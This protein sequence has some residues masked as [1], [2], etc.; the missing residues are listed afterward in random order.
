MP[1]I[2]IGL[3][4][5]FEGLQR[6][7]GYEALAGVKMALAERNAAGGVAGYRVELVAL[8]DFGEPEEARLQAREFAVDPAVIGVVTGWTDETARASLPVYQQ[9]GLA[10]VVAWSVS[11][12]LAERGSGVVL[13]AA[14]TQRAAGE[15][16]EVVAIAHPRQV[17]VVADESS[18]ALYQE[19]LVARGLEARVLS[20][21]GALD[22]R[23]FQEQPPDALLLATDGATAG[24]VL[25]TQKW[26]VI[27]FGGAEAGSV[28]VTS[29]GGQ[30]ADGFIF[31]SPAP[32]GRDA[33]Q[34][35]SAVAS[36]LEGLGPRAV[37]AYD[38]THVL[39][40]AI[41]L[42]VRENG[43]P[44]RA[45]VASALSRVRRDGLTGA[46]AFDADG[47]RLNVPVW[48]YK[49]VD[50]NYPGQRVVLPSLVGDE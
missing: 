50:A 44:D 34:A 6:P 2:K 1:L 7:L 27:A 3:A 36:D 12:E 43:H 49:I 15:L 14:D 31:V 4:A 40:D 13:V 41:E 42:A 47:R 17:L 23:F 9:A 5:P 25:A 29:V 32:A 22:D 20:L 35:E 30:A 46:I 26:E 28:H 33:M 19:A 10:V 16:A 45:G 18:S 24:E 39:L 11:P 8:N 37:L 21:A 48:L 38:A